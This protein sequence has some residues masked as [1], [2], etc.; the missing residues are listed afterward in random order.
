LRILDLT[1]VGVGPFTTKFF[2][3]H[4]A[5]VL[6][7]ESALRPDGL[8]TMHPATG[9]KI[10][11]NRG[12]YYANRNSGKHSLGVDLARP[13][14][15]ALVKRLV[16]L[17]DVVVSNFRPGVMEKFGLGY[18]TVRELRKDVIYVSMPM[19]GEAGP[20]R[21]FAGYGLILG[22]MAGLT[23]VTRYDDGPPQGTG[24]NFP[25]HVPNPVHGATAILAALLKRARTGEGEAIEIS[26]LE[27]SVNFIGPA[28]LQA[29]AIGVDPA[30]AD[31]GSGFAPE[32]VF[33]CSGE[34]QWCAISCPSDDAWMAL[35]DALELPEQ[36]GHADYNTAR[37]RC[38]N[39]SL[40]KSWI[41]QATAHRDKHA[42]AQ[43]L[44]GRGVAAA[45]VHDIAEAM[46][47]AHLRARGHWI[48]LP[49]MEGEGDAIYNAP[50]VHFVGEEEVPMTRAP[51][52]GEHTRN[53]CR[54]LLSM[55]AGAIERA[56]A[57]GI[58]FET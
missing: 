34:D 56:V 22:A 15:L 20:Y 14:G 41:A 17:C 9:G 54:E 39:A 19:F 7:I 10:G 33:A 36:A 35:R 2:S 25:D 24:T 48:R 30:P 46:A 11:L 57:E 12:G 55:D 21:E 5:E 8:R 49:A 6:K 31:T 58:L 44:R 47:D 40:L 27:S 4:G 38:A 13:E 32:G 37:G 1:W 42:L 29:A 28:L 53:I 43:M 52:L 16:P 18:E 51:R 3:D 23:A 26:Q 45:A 50:P